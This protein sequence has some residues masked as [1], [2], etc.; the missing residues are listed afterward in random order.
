M[1]ANVLDLS[2]F[3]EMEAA[4]GEKI[5]KEHSCIAC[6]QIEEDGKALGG[7]QS[8]SFLDAGKR[9]NVDWV[10]RF[11]MKPP[12]FVRTAVNSKQMSV[13]WGSVM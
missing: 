1:K 7:S 6:H 2:R 3:S 12:D 5:F 10:Y 9:L 8:T 11:N 4:L 13:S